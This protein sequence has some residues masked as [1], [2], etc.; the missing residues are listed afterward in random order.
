MLWSVPLSILSMQDP[1]IIVLTVGFQ[2]CWGRD[3]KRLKHTSHRALIT[4]LS[5]ADTHNL[6][7]SV[8]QHGSQGSSTKQVRWYFIPFV[9]WV[10]PTPFLL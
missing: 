10:A 4:Q 2:G 9:G 8:S 7:Y 5:A 1:P 3:G 6:S